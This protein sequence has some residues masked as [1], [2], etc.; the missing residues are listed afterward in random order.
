MSPI[1]D[2]VAR[3]LRTKGMTMNPAPPERKSRDY[4]HSGEGHH[5]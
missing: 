5:C 1:N 4:P 2:L 3:P